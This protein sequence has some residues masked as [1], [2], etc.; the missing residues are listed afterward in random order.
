LAG[1]LLVF[2]VTNTASD[3]GTVNIGLWKRIQKKEVNKQSL[4]RQK[5]N[6]HATN[7]E[8]NGQKGGGYEDHL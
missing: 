2:C 8:L 3:G 4:W 6:N 5:K 1:G 7:K